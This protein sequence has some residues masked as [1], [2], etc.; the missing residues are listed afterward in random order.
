VV[1]VVLPRHVRRTQ[2]GCQGY[3]APEP[4]APQFY[5]AL[6]RLALILPFI[7]AASRRVTAD[8]NKAR[9]SRRMCLM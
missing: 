4:P 1:L 8:R 6:L 3:C 2:Y 9:V 7:Q 5:P